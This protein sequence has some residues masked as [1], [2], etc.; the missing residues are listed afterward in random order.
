M[1]PCVTPTPSFSA[2]LQLPI[3]ILDTVRSDSDDSDTDSDVIPVPVSPAVPVSPSVYATPLTSPLAPGVTSDSDGDHFTYNANKPGAGTSGQCQQPS[4]AVNTQARAHGGEMEL[5]TLNVCQQQQQQQ[6]QQQRDGSEVTQSGRS[7]SQSRSEDGVGGRVRSPAQSCQTRPRQ[8]NN[9]AQSQQQQHNN[10]ESS[11]RQGDIGEI[12]RDDTG[13]SGRGLVLSGPEKIC[14]LS[15]PDIC[16]DKSASDEINVDNS[17]SV[18]QK[19]SFNNSSSEKDNHFELLTTTQQ[20]FKSVTTTTSQNNS[21][22]TS[23]QY[24]DTGNIMERGDHFSS[25]RRLNS[26][27]GILEQESEREMQAP[28]PAGRQAK[29]K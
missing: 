25:L 12:C 2:P 5:P 10:S 24:E 20:P 9:N 16:G 3:V 19:Q 27:L 11:N 15:K 22:S 6:Q 7:R 8:N 26:L 21:S 4:H 17:S 29:V 13:I 14:T 28:A 18:S 23:D 1:S